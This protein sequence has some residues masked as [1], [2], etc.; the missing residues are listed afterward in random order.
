M[1]VEI[2]A[3]SGMDLV[4]LR[5][6]YRQLH[7]KP[8]PA[9]VPRWLLIRIVACRMQALVHGDLDPDTLRY[10]GRVARDQRKGLVARTQPPVDQDPPEPS[11][12]PFPPGFVR[13]RSWSANM[14]ANCTR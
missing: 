3:L 13:A 12:H 5:L 14:V 2:E 6:R 11:S 10:L 7:R 1:E 4:A 9:H 8:A